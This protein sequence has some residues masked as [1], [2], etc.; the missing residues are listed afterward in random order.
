MGES[1]ISNSL[2]ILTDQRRPHRTGRTLLSSTS[3]AKLPFSCAVRRWTIR[4]LAAYRITLA[5]LVF[6][7]TSTLYGRH[8]LITYKEA[9]A[10]IPDLVNTAL[11]RLVTQAA[12]KEDDRGDGFISVDQLRDDVLRQVFSAR[13]RERVW[14]NVRK[15]VEGNA[16]VRAAKRESDRTGDVSRVWEWIGP[17]NMAPGLEGRKSGLLKNNPEAGLRQENEVREWDE[18]RPIY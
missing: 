16:N 4:T 1:T 12:L 9:T 2:R 15:I 14:Q 10:Q 3:L 18:G 6:A 8:R 17:V 7:A 13:E 11:D 5:L